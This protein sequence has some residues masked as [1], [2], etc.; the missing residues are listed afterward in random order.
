MLE[1]QYKLGATLLKGD[2][3][4]QDVDKAVFLHRQAA[5]KGHAKAQ[6]SLAYSYHAGLEVFNKIS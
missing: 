1:T 4:K 6:V 5:E 3:V 2:G